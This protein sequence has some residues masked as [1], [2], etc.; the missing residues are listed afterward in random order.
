MIAASFLARIIYDFRE[1]V[2]DD[3]HGSIIGGGGKK[4]IVYYYLITRFRK[5]FRGI[6]TGSMGVVDQAG[7]ILFHDNRFAIQRI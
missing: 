3:I 7:G 4:T 1:V 5:V 6:I 2:R